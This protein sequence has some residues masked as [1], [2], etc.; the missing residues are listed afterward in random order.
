MPDTDDKACPCAFL[1]KNGYLATRREA[2]DGRLALSL[3]EIET[4]PDEAVLHQAVAFLLCCAERA[5][6]RGI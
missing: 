5:E 2:R 1:T 6:K 3:R 4:Q